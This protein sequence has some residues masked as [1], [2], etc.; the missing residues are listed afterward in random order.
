MPELVFFLPLRKIGQQLDRIM[1][2]QLFRR[3]PLVLTDLLH[4][5][6][7]PFPKLVWCV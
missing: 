1:L 5:L 3:E 4:A 7:A 2:F 6:F